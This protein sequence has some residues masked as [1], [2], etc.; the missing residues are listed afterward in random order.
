MGDAIIK[1]VVSCI[2]LY[3]FFAAVSGAAAS[4]QRIQWVDVSDGIREGG[5]RSVAVDPDN[6]DMVFVCSDVAVYKSF[7]GGRTWDEILSFRTT[8]KSLNTVFIPFAKPLTVYTGTRDGLLRSSDGGLSWERVFSGVG[9]EKNSV[10]SIA[11]DPESPGRIVIGT[12]AGVFFSEDN[13]KSWAKGQNLPSD[14]AIAHLAMDS[15]NPY[16][17][18]AAADTG[19]YK[20]LNGGNGWRKILDTTAAD[21]DHLLSTGEED[22]D[23]EIEGMKSIRSI[24]IDPSNSEILYAATSRGLRIS[25]DGGGT[26]KRAG[27]LGLGSLDIRHILLHG[28]KSSSLYAATGRG[29]FR[30]SQTSDIWEELYKGMLSP[31]IHFLALS[32]VN[33][34]K[35]KTLWAATR[36]GVYRAELPVQFLNGSFVRNGTGSGEQ[37]VRKQDMLSIFSHEPTI[38]EVREAAIQYAEVQ[39]EKILKWRKAAARRAWLPDVKVAYGKNKDWQSSTYFY[40]TSSEKYKDD[41]VTKGKDKA[42]S[43]SLDWE[44]GDLI[45]NSAQTSIDTRSRLVVQLR[46]DVLAEVTRLYFE[47]RRLMVEMLISPSEGIADSI[48]NELRLQELTA[49]LDALTGSYFSRKLG[50]GSGI[51]GQGPG[52]E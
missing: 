46:D 44:L 25:R 2:C 6:P 43:I 50:Q 8:P 34:D 21:D 9:S 3:L 7:N 16:L 31:E 51:R 27:S 32:N 11:V 42:W 37:N 33:H 26:W 41:D 45:W 28:D 13:G 47:R 5:I 4:G 36:K 48:E 15:A 29:V 22:D 38:G 18:Y 30:Y 52:T 20:S 1:R 19:L 10:L 23:D 24:V 14:T 49:G 40:S 12:E 35:G 39:P 17:V